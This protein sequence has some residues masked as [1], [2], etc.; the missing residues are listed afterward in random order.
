[1]KYFLRYHRIVITTEF[2]MPKITIRNVEICDRDIIVSLKKQLATD[3]PFLPYDSKDHLHDLTIIKKWRKFKYHYDL[4]EVNGR[5]VGYLL[6]QRFT[7]PLGYISLGILSEFQGKG[8]G[9]L[10]IDNVILRAIEQRFKEL[11][12]LVSITNTKALA[13]YHRYGFEI[14]EELTSDNYGVCYKMILVL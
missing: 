10:L 5:V 8:Y 4:L 14:K 9:S 3:S 13:L 11:A 1:M 6:F 2:F 7:P 12:L